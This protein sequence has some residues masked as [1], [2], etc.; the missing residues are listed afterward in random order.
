VD[1]QNEA[2]ATVLS[3]RTVNG[4]ILSVSQKSCASPERIEHAA[5]GSMHSGQ[6]N[7][8]MLEMLAHKITPEMLDDF[9]PPHVTIEAEGQCSFTFVRVRQKNSLGAPSLLAS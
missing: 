3:S 2:S 8:S 7:S 1:Y 9:W 4:V 6:T 5:Q